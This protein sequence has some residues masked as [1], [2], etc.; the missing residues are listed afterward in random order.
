MRHAKRINHLGRTNTHRAAMLSNMATSLIM[1]KRISTTLA[2]AKELRKYVEPLINR[3]KNDTTHSRRVVFSYLQN[4]YAVTE[5]F[6]EI[7]V[8]VADR[9][10]GYTRILKTGFR[11]G[12]NAE[13]CI[14]ELVDY[15][16]T[17]TAGDTKKKA[18][19]TRRSKKKV[20]AIAAPEANEPVAAPVAE[21]AAAEEAGE[22]E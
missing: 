22:N 4:K 12:D 8:R 19:R 2:K 7:S 18:T 9:P 15:N 13:M 10:G 20:E 17:Y 11:Q 21:T 14:I 1:H 3:S 5:L 6:R 16:E